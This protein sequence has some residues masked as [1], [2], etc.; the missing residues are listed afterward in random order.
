MG[1]GERIKRNIIN[2]YLIGW[3]ITILGYLLLKYLFIQIILSFIISI[4]LNIYLKIFNLK[5]KK[6]KKELWK[7]LKIDYYIPNIIKILDYIF[8]LFVV[9]KV[10]KIIYNSW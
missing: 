3:P 9:Y 5:E 8:W 10:I 6:N 4:I 1:K 7:E 2:N